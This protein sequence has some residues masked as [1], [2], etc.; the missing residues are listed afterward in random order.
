MKIDLKLSADHL[1]VLSATF[2]TLGD[3]PRPKE[4]VHRATRNVV[5]LLSIK[6][7]KKNI[8]ITGSTNLFNSKS[9]TKFTLHY[10]EAF[11]LTEFLTHT[12]T[13]QAFQNDYFENVIRMIR[14][15]L[16]QKLA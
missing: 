4:P 15:E 16:K 3:L 11:C 6:V 8:E 9:K 13:E 10:F 7:Q 1:N 14:D 12:I 5:E 2:Q